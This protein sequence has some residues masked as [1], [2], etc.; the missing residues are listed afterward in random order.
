MNQV[1]DSVNKMNGCQK[2]VNRFAPRSHTAKLAAVRKKSFSHDMPVTVSVSV[3]VTVKT[4]RYTRIYKC[5]TNRVSMYKIQQYLLQTLVQY[6]TVCTLL[7]AE[8][9]LSVCLCGYPQPTGPQQATLSPQLLQP[10]LLCLHTC[11]F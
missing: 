7:P 3:P 2:S 8:C 4:Y 6:C 10:T 1:T 9:S 11:G 5:W